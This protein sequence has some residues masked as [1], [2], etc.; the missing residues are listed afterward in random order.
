MIVSFQAVA[1][2]EDA[3]EAAK[4]IAKRSGVVDDLYADKSIEGLA[5]YENLQELL[6]GVKEFVD[7]PERDEKT[8]SAFLQEISLLTDADKKEDEGGEHVTMMTIHSAKG[9][10]FRNVYIVGM[11]ENL[12]PSQM[13]ISSRSD[14]EEERRLFYVAITRAEKKLTLTYATSRYQWG[15]LRSCEPSRFLN[16]IDPT[17]LKISFAPTGDSSLPQPDSGGFGKVVERRTSTKN[18]ITPPA[19]PSKPTN[20][21]MPADFE[22]SDTSN[23]QA[24]MR[25]EHPKFGYGNV[26]SVDRQ[27]AGTKAV[28]AFDEL[29]EKTLL[30]TFAKLRIH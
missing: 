29:G 21:V 7:N 16:E 8:L 26:K 3:F 11:E 17:Y 15:N 1:Q 18:L 9:L 12:F 13:M 5:R 24:G 27:P 20:Y 25:V 10:E 6:N 30:L 19:K 22:P 23:L 2:K 28:V 4:H 14:L